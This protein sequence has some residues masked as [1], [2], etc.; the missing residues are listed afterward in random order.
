[1]KK[2]MNP[3]ETIFTLIILLIVVIVMIN[4]FMNYVDKTKKDIGTTLKDIKSAM[5]YRK[6]ISECEQ[7]C[8]D[9]LNGEMVDKI[10]YCSMRVEIDI[11]MDKRIDSDAPY[12]SDYY[13][14]MPIYAAAIPYVVCEENIYCPMITECDGLS[15]ERCRRILCDYWMKGQN[16]IDAASNM[17]KNIYNPGDCE[18]DELINLSGTKTNWY[19]DLKFYTCRDEITDE[20]CSEIYGGICMDPEECRERGGSSKGPCTDGNVCCVI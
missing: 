7:A 8:N 12:P 13:K 2:G 20:E 16:D 18:L 6:A 4:F 5:G 1:M 14:N 15:M 11:N 17:L 10:N 9:A 19:R 3:L